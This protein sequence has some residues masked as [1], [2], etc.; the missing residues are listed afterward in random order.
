MSSLEGK[1][2]NVTA[3]HVYHEGL[4]LCT[5]FF[6][7]KVTYNV[8]MKNAGKIILILAVIAALVLAFFQREQL[9]RISSLFSEI[10]IGLLLL[11][12][13]FQALT[14][15]M[16]GFSFKYLLRI[17]N[18]E[19][20]IVELSNAGLG[21]T[22]INQMLPAAGLTAAPLFPA[23]KSGRT[24]KG[25]GAVVAVTWFALYYLLFFALLFVG[26]LSLFF[27]DQLRR[28]QVAPVATLVVIIFVLIVVGYFIVRKKERL[29][30]LFAFVFSRIL[31]KV[32]VLRKRAE[33]WRVRVMRFVDELYRAS[34]DLRDKKSSLFAPAFFVLLLHLL[35]LLTMY[36]LL[37]NFGIET[38]F[39]VL[40]VGYCLANFITMISTVP[41]G[42]GVFEASMSLTYA[43]LGVPFDQALVA[44]LIFRALAFWIIMPIGAVSYHHFL[45]DWGF[46]NRSKK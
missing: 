29:E 5:I 36:V 24:N 1:L 6:L 14:Y 38:P 30:R 27:D 44:V 45:N 15:V 13:L 46:G 11:A 7:H 43:S 37:L 20:K 12:I 35:D 3:P 22:F 9:I 28:S 41:L 42:I 31:T 4:V 32:P 16:Q 10:S 33:E 34:A 40:A 8:G 19:G 17:Y 26:F 39:A 23:L 21:Y 25:E 2:K 18:K